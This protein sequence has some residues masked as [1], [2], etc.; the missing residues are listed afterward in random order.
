MIKKNDTSIKH[1]KH[2]TFRCESKTN[3]YLNHYIIKTDE[4]HTRIIK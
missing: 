1:I 2:N 4:T 3:S